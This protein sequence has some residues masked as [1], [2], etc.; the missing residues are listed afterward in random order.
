MVTLTPEEF[1][2]QYCGGGEAKKQPEGRK[3]T[4]SDRESLENAFIDAW[5]CLFKDLPEPVPQHRFHKTRKFRFDWAWPE[6]KLAVECVGGCFIQGGHNRGVIQ[7]RDHEKLNL[8]QADS[9]VVLQYGTKAFK[10]PYRIAAEV[11]EVLR[12]RMTPRS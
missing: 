10:D 7:E 11:A 9:W 4:K 8:A 12:E 5:R 6:H 1:R 3:V 2:R